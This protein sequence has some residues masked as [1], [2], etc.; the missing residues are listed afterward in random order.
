MKHF[1]YSQYNIVVCDNNRYITL[2]NSY[3]GAIVKLEKEVFEAIKAGNFLLSDVLYGQELLDNGFI[4]NSQINEFNRAKAQIESVL[5]DSW[6]ETVSYVIAPTLNCNLDCIY[7][8][9]KEYR[10]QGNEHLLTDE[11]LSKIETFLIKRNSGNKRLRKVKVNWFG[12]EPL[13]CYNQIVSF[14]ESII[15]ELEKFE[16][17]FECSMITNGILLDED[18]LT[19]LTKKCNLRRI[20]ITLDGEEDTYCLKKHTTTENYY[21]VIKNIC[22]ATKYAKTTVRVNADKENFNELVRLIQSLLQEDIHKENL[23]IHFA[24]LRDYQNRCAT[25]PLFTDSEFWQYRKQ[26][27]DVLKIS[28]D[29]KRDERDRLGGL[30]LAPF[31]GLARKNNFVID[32]LGN[33]YK[34]EHYIG[35][36]DRIVGNIE[37]GIYYN[38]EYLHS[39]TLSVDQR[40]TV[41]DIFPQCNYSR[42][43]AMHGFAGMGL[44]CRCYNEQLKV[45]KEKAKK[46]L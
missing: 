13:L 15:Y 18:R 9:Q 43:L 38:D 3:S 41:C 12:G 31:C 5:T 20:Q 16:I 33:L 10:T 14:C 2:Y 24:Q 44:N 46:Y 28:Q 37:D 11:T 19:E 8:F 40:C 22:I 27:Y 29:D 32:Y 34:C 7:C 17:G 42:C 4:V 45:I 39:M 1:K 30:P 23:S 36:E 35:D 6:Q 25:Y 26:F 21:K